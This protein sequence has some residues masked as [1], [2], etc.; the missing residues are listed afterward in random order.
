M[1]P[2]SVYKWKE[3]AAITEHP[4]LILRAR[5][6]ASRLQGRLLESYYLA[7]SNALT[8]HAER[9]I[10]L[11]DKKLLEAALA[12]G[13]PII[14]ASLHE[15]FFLTAFNKLLTEFRGQR[16]LNVFYADPVDN[17]TT[18]KFTDLLAKQFPDCKAL[19]NNPRGIVSARKALANNGC[20]FIMPDIFTNIGETI[21]V[22]FCSRLY[23]T[24][25]G[26]AFLA[27]KSD[28]LVVPIITRATGL[29]SFS[30]LTP[31]I[32]DARDYQSANGMEQAIHDL[33]TDM[34]RVFEKHLKEDPC[35]WQFWE[36]FLQYGV[37][38]PEIS[39]AS[40]LP[41]LISDWSKRYPQ[42]ATLLQAG[43]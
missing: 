34:W 43:N 10:Q 19:Y 37:P 5:F 35:G 33:T 4:A 24:M 3:V 39:E 41:N 36:Q 18:Q 30:V 23:P 13:R 6:F 17:P 42:F 22:P 27:I 21:Y 26:T 25:P 14:F 29:F 7:R 38:I 40:S 2:K 20:V 15:N 31:S 9:W 12:T 1:K 28:S 11:A 8:N 16:S 32:I